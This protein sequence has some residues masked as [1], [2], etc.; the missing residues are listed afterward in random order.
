MRCARARAPVWPRD[1]D[2]VGGR[3]GAV[4]GHQCTQCVID[5]RVRVP[6]LCTAALHP[7]LLCSVDCP[8]AFLRLTF[9]RKGPMVSGQVRH[10]FS[11][12]AFVLPAPCAHAI[13][14]RSSGGHAPQTPPSPQRP[15]P[16]PRARIATSAAQ[17]SRGHD[18]PQVP[19]C[20]G[21]VGQAIAYP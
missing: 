4:G 5:S 8:R 15:C 21:D 11:F 12:C 19:N 20:R 16:P 2:A 17:Q 9:D 6:A 14:Q 1:A 3:W 18:V 13:A 7:P 10:P